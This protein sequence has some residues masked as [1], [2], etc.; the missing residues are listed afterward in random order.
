MQTRTTRDGDL[1]AHHNY[2]AAVLQSIFV[3]DVLREMP[4]TVVAGGY[5]AAVYQ[6]LQLQNEGFQP[7][8]LD[9]FV[10]VSVNVH[11]IMRLYDLVVLAPLGLYMHFTR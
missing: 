4:C 3:R 11:N 5:P 9:I 2:R 8:D 7:S 1:A 6:Y 10:D